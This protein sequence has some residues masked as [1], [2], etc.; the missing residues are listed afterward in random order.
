M[1]IPF[2]GRL[3]V[4][5]GLLAVAGA[6]ASGIPVEDAARALATFGGGKRRLERIGMAAGVDVFDSYNF[7]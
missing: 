6:I 7:V 5:N 2:P 3:T 1:R 4:E